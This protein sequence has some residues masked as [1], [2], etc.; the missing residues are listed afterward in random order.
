MGFQHPK[1]VESRYK[2]LGV[3]L[4]PASVALD[5]MINHFQ[6]RHVLVHNGGRIDA[7]YI[8][9]VPTTR[10]QP[11]DFL[12]ISEEKA[13]TVMSDFLSLVLHI[14]DDIVRKNLLGQGPRVIDSLD[15]EWKKKVMSYLASYLPKG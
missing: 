2:I 5:R 6:D 12:P 1:S 15:Q 9:N 4:L 3:A 7:D 8:K 14:E 11:G 10:C 13:E